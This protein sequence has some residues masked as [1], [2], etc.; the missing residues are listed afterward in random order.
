MNDF[1]KEPITKEYILEGI[2]ERSNGVALNF[3]E[4]YG[5][6]ISKLVED[7]T[8]SFKALQGIID[9][10]VENQV[11]END[12]QSAL[13]FWTALNTYVATIELFRRGYFLE[14]SMLLRNI[15][16][17][18]GVAYDIHLHPEKLSLLRELEDRYD[19]PKSISILKSIHPVVGAMYGQLSDMFTHVNV[20]HTLPQG[21]YTGS[22]PTLWIGGGFNEEEKEKHLYGLS[23]LSMT[24]DLLSITMELTFYEEL[25]RHKYWIKEPDGSYKYQPNERVNART[26]DIMERFGA[27]LQEEDEEDSTNSNNSAS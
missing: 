15:L 12:W 16:E 26:D 17:I 25:E 6:D 19:S 22:R 27:L 20:L 23:A 21:T 2:K 7:V 14:P 10:E 13:L 18:L 24:L 11:K 8:E 9:R 3:D 5:E 1:K 4:E